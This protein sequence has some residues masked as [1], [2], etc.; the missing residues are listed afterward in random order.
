MANV[1]GGPADAA[2]TQ[3]EGTLVAQAA[4][5]FLEFLSGFRREDD[6][7]EDGGAVEP[8]YKT[9]VT[10]MGF[11][12]DGVLHIDFVDVRCFNLSL[13]N[14]MQQHYYEVEGV[15]RAQV[16]TERH[17]VAHI[18]HT[19]T[20]AHARTH[21]TH[22]RTH[23]HTRTHSRTNIRTHKHLVRPAWWTRAL[24]R[25][26]S[27]P[28]AALTRE[29]ERERP[30]YRI[31]DTFIHSVRLQIPPLGHPGIRP[32]PVPKHIPRQSFHKSRKPLGSEVVGTYTR[33]DSGCRR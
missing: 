25:T 11:A 30:R 24:P 5:Q 14:L 31:R 19:H 26:S 28:R 16:R 12:R 17:R 32:M 6:T 23:A 29:R 15:L 21:K 10:E 4:K 1:G 13:A 8:F 3:G 7:M 22:A 27:Q 9:A 18:G 20:H 2:F 33:R